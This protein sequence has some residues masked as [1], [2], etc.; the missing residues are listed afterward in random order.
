[1]DTFSVHRWI[2]KK[3]K[4]TYTFG[5]ESSEPDIPI[6]I[7]QD[8]SLT[9]TLTKIALGIR[10]YHLARKESAP[11]IDSVPYFWSGK[12]SLRFELPK[13]IPANP[14]MFE[15]KSKA[16][17][18]A[19]I[20][21]VTD[22]LFMKTSVNVIFKND[23]PE[24]LWPIYFPDAATKWRP[25][26][27]MKEFLKE[28]DGL[29]ALWNIEQ[30]IR[31]EQR[32]FTF[33]KIRFVGKLK[34]ITKSLS[35]TFEQMHSSAQFP[36]IQYIEDTSKVLYKVWKKHSISP[37]LMQTWTFYDR[38]PKVPMIIIMVPLEREHSFA[39]TTLDSSGNISIQYQIDSRDKIEWEIIESHSSIIRKW[40]EQFFKL[41]LSL[42]VD[43]ISGKGEFASQ[44]I[45]IQE[46]SKNVGK[47]VF[48]P[49]YHVIR[50]QDGTLYVAF[51]RSE[52]Y[53]SDLDISDYISSN[54]KLGIPLQEIAQNLTDLGLTQKEVLLW[55]EQYQTQ[56][57]TDAD[58]PKKK[59][60]AF[61]G[62]LFKIEKA[63][64]GFRVLMENVASLKELEFIYRWLRA[65]FKYIMN[66]HKTLP[67]VQPTP[68][69]APAQ[70]VAAPSA[71]VVAPTPV[72]ESVPTSSSESS[73]ILNQDISFGGAGKKGKGTDRY[74]LTQLQQTDP[75]IFLDTKNYARLCAANNFRQPIVVSQAEKAKIDAEGYKNSYD[76]S[77]LYGSDQQHLNNYMCPRI[78]CPTSRIPLTEKQLEDN[79]GK[80]PGPHFEQPMK[81]YENT[82]WDDNPKIPHHIGFHKQKTP[83]GLCLPCCMKNPMKD[84]EK[85]DC[86]APES[87]TRAQVSTAKQKTPAPASETAPASVT[88]EEGYIMG[89]VAPLQPDRYGALPKDLHTFLQPKTPYQLCSKTISST[90]CYL[91]KGILHNEDSIMNAIATSLGMKSKKDLIKEIIKKL[92]VISFISLANGH[93]LSAFM[94]QEPI[95][96]KENPK[97]VKE[98][99]AWIK[100]YPSYARI[101]NIN[102]ITDIRLSREL[103]I[104]KA[105]SNFI[106]YLKSDDLKN[107]EHLE[108][109]LLSGGIILLI[110]KRAGDEATL[111][112]NTYSNVADIFVA[113]Q[114]KRIAMLLQE[115]EYYEPIE[116]KQ[117]G[118]ISTPLFDENGSLGDIVKKVL[119]Q[120]P[121]PNTTDATTH[122][123]E[124]RVIENLRNLV[125]WC[126]SRLSNANRFDI[127]TVILRQDLQIYGFMTR[128]NMFIRGPQ[129]GINIHILPELFDI[130]PS[131][132]KLVYL[133]DISGHTFTIGENYANDFIVFREKIADLGF[134]LDAGNIDID[135]REGL[136]SGEITFPPLNLSI[137]PI[138]RTRVDDSLRQNEKTLKDVDK[139]WYQ[140]QHSVGNTLLKHYESLVT[141]LLSLT[142]K[143][144]IRILM[145]TFRQIPEKE[146]IQIT[147]EEIPLEYGKDA[148]VKWIRQIGLEKRARI[149]TSSFV[150]PSKKEW[151][152]SQAAVEHGL[153]IEVLKP[154]QTIHPN[155]KY[156]TNRVKDYQSLTTPTTTSDSII[157]PSMIQKT[158]CE[159]QALPSK[160]SV[161]KSGTS[162][163]KYSWYKCPY[164]R[165]SI[166][167]LF[168]WISSRLNLPFSWVDIQDIRNRIII[169]LLQNKG[170]T[171]IL[172]EDP[173]FLKLW[174][175]SLNKKYKDGD[176][177]WAHALASHT[178]QRR[179]EV[180]I[181]VQRTAG[182]ANIWPMDIDLK[183]IAELMNISILVIYRGKYG[184]GTGT[185]KR[186]AVEDLYISSTFYHGNERSW[187]QRPCVMFYRIIEKDKVSFSA[188]VN[189]TDDT[190]IHS[191]V[192]SMPKD[193]Q[194]LF[195]FHVQ[196]ERRRDEDNSSSSSSSK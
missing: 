55:I 163:S 2:T 153:P 94:D 142:K 144:R 147:L 42:H 139:K 119:E 141:P 14:W 76:D 136:I 118:K 50:I 62:C 179:T 134:V 193:I 157:I 37:T 61:S 74:F 56:T 59:S 175:T 47:G 130:I 7:F 9:K 161:L 91:R 168:E 164:I 27:T 104:F 188:I 1:M 83:T 169:A 20:T 107:P 120:C 98:W 25:V 86:K 85:V 64:Y 155:E 181:N 145:N 34:N 185:A 162:W 6:I 196:K 111:Q 190:F 114:N 70:P 80:C 72:S 77:I 149:Y 126:A 131:L 176:D 178:H 69:A 32:T 105:Y 67:T 54:I 23:A 43:S 65:T 46:I 132:A 38:L 184:E 156:A 73:D 78:W 75:A 52:N 177:L 123:R 40:F 129:E 137:I 172:F 19:Q 68:R 160:W 167:S 106:A 135:Q 8:D 36:F 4:I 146:K 101:V 158:A 183:T 187:L 49:L 58:V 71:P 26:F 44:G 66:S 152:F 124:R 148:L 109:L 108:T 84:R 116:L 189:T 100:D 45:G 60:I 115:K 28:Y 165:T 10:E 57:Q 90:E 92:D 15:E 12:K 16:T 39:R 88:K 35:E 166:P 180:W 82:Y 133:E 127:R 112:C 89:A 31:E 102:D 140:L 121:L 11:S 18:A 151:E 99:R 53:H 63:P 87:G 96:A 122:P 154:V 3:R 29:Y 17:A 51:K 195:K 79:N 30:A 33:S 93:I 22:A 48:I 5:P 143:E 194:E 182:L 170:E 103:A 128:T 110:W 159:L 150:K 24:K 97:L 138:I 117:R 95:I 125:A 13:E 21:Y 191:T 171:L 186:G 192:S 41:S 81:L 173:G 113:G 174:N